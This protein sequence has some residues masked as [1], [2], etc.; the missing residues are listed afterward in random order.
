MAIQKQN[1]ND[2]IKEVMKI[3]L[4][5][6]NI[7]MTVHGN[8]DVYEVQQ[9]VDGSYDLYNKSTD[10]ISYGLSCEGRADIISVLLQDYV[11]GIL[12]NIE[13]A[14]EREKESATSKTEEELDR[15]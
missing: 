3:T 9:Y 5:S 11:T 6:S 14:D 1:E 7:K 8:T 10:H 12:T 15:E 13:V 2:F 4:E